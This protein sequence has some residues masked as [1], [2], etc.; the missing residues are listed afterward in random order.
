VSISNIRTWAGGPLRQMAAT[1][2]GGTFIPVCQKHERLS[3]C[4]V[5]TSATGVR[6]LVRASRS[7]MTAN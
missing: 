4:G 3:F 6:S 5:G 2:V 7:K 1:K